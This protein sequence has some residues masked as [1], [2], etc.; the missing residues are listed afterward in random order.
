MVEIRF[1][2][3]GGQGAFTAARLLGV[4]VTLFEN[5]HALAFPSFG[6][7]RRGSPVLGFIRI[8]DQKIADRSIIT[9]CDVVVV[10]DDTLLDASILNGLQRGGLLLVNTAHSELPLSVP[11]HVRTVL[12]DATA[13][14]LQ[15]LGRPIANTGML[16]VLAA[17]SEVVTLQSLLAA[18]RHE[19][20]GSSAEKNA[21]LL[22]ETFK[23]SGGQIT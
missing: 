15:Y 4:A 14:A 11:A 2:G 23:A 3:R 22:E 16:G 19:M 9:R 13:L 18:V 1:H 10:L 12:V 6:P 8:D 21:V 20:K 17:L 7:E 5:R